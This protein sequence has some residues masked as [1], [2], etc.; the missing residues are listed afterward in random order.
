[1]AGI[2]I[3]YSWGACYWLRFQNVV[4]KEFQPRVKKI[5]SLLKKKPL[6][7]TAKINV[8]KNCPLDWQKVSKIPK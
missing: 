2:F 1:M 8:E 7:F 3:T 6:P 5:R 4:V